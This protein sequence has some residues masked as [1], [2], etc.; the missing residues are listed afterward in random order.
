MSSIELHLSDELIS[1]V[2]EENSAKGT[3]EKLEKFYTEKS[4]SNKLILKDQ[5]YWLKMEEDRDI[6]AHLKDFNLCISDLIQVNVKY[7]EDNKAL[8]LLRS[9]SDSF[10]H[11]KNTLLFGKDTL[12]SDAVVSDIISYV[13]GNDFLLRSLVTGVEQKKK[14][15]RRITLDPN[16][17]RTM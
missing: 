17:E 10:K 13:R 2:M 11:F 8:L 5:L 15:S 14:L 12:K 16:L 1:N 9:L 6:M 3:W 7:E 4:L